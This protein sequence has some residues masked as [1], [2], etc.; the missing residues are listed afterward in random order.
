MQWNVLHRAM[1]PIQLRILPTGKRLAR[2]NHARGDIDR[3][4]TVDRLH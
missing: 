2:C 4:D 3:I 1:D